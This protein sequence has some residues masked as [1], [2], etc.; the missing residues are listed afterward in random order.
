MFGFFQNRRRQKLLEQPMP[1]AWRDFLQ[2]NVAIY[3]RLSAAEKSR[4]E[5][6]V[7]IIVA[8]RRFVGCGGLT[9]T[10]EMKVTIAAQAALLLLGE[11]GYYFDKVPTIFIFPRPRADKVGRSVQYGSAFSSGAH[12]IEEGVI[13]EGQAFAQGEIRLAW[14][15]VLSGGRDD[16]DGEN[17]VLHELAHHLDS[18]D[19]ELGGTPPLPDEASRQRWWQI[20]DAELAQL[21]RDLATGQQSLLH[22]AAADSRCELFAYA[23]ELFF[24]QPVE[25]RRDHAELYD[26]L[27]DFYKIDPTR[28]FE[29]S[30]LGHS[31]WEPDNDYS[32]DDNAAPTAL[33]PP[34]ETADQYFTRGLES[35]E[36]EDFEAAEAD[37][38]RAVK[39]SP[40]DEEAVLYRGRAR[41]YLG[42][43]EAALADAERAC[44]LAPDDAEAIALRGI[45][46]VA[47][48]EMASGLQDLEHIEDAQADDLDALYH[49]GVARAECGRTQDA[50]ADFSRLI[51]LDPQDAAAWRERSACY[52]D[53]GNESAAARDLAQARAL[54][55]SVE[56]E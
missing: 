44:R 15:E 55:W 43:Y 23:T 22:D 49:R 31:S 21:R 9:V 25:L 8:E 4:L 11:G 1:A 16:S 35:F 12:V 18:L 42:E 51:Q 46:R 52:A 29:A 47:L 20:F 10:D 54:G 41:F 2:R 24:E 28:W 26:C 56:D 36:S 27:Q 38:D 6:A 48:G 45:C 39:L 14:S 13:V 17:V 19:G 30:N 34:L 37:F 32:A 7:V 5:A 40:Q 33:L 53:L 50:I 3:S